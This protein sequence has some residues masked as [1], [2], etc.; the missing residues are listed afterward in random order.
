MADSPPASP[1]PPRSA[2][3][4]PAAAL[5]ALAA[6]RERFLASTENT[7]TAFRGFARQLALSPAAP[8]VVEGLRREL[9]RV[10]GTAGTYGF[11]EASRLAARMEEQA[12]RWAAAPD[13]DVERRA[14]IVEHF[15]EALAAAFVPEAAPPTPPPDAG[16]AGVGAGP[17]ATAPRAPAAPPPPAGAPS[18]HAAGRRRR[19]V[20][21]GID[22]ELSHAVRAEAVL[23]AFTCVTLDPAGCTADALRTLAPH[24]LVADGPHAAAAAAACAVAGVPVIVL[25]APAGVVATSDAALL[26]AGAGAAE[27]LAAAERLAARASWAGATVLV[28]DDDPAVL[29]VVRAVVE[30]SGVHVRTLDDPSAIRAVLVGAPPSLLLMDVDM[31]GENGVAITRELRAIPAYATLPIMLFSARSDPAVRQAAYDA[32]ADEFLPKPIVVDELRARVSDRLER[33]RLQRLSDGLHPGTGLPLP[34]RAAREAGARVSAARLAG[35][36]YTLAVIRPDGAEPAGPAAAAWL[37]ECERVAAHL[38]AGGATVGYHDGAAL[39][40]VMETGAVA[41]VATLRAAL[42]ARDGAAPAWRAG[43]VSGI[44]AP[45]ADLAALRRWAVEAVAAADATGD[46]AVAQWRGELSAEAPDV[47]VVEP[48]PSLSKL[49][50]YALRANGFSFRTFESGPAALA[51]LLSMPVSGRR[52]VVLLDVDLP[53]LD[54][55]SLHE[56]LRGERPG[57]FTVVFT[58]VHGGEAEQV[59]A[60]KGGAVDYIVKPLSVRVLMVKVGIWLELIGRAA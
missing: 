37:R 28:V 60:L 4:P 15:V 6:L 31:G 27:L 2:G 13:L 29:A 49:V 45:A 33:Q 55:H 12:V 3:P 9:H 54:G 8:A 17:P 41:A 52:P 39:L 38:T 46:G 25:G 10:H 24:V 34:P 53:G 56:R 22:G 42:A 26:P 18:L 32:G 21:V 48:D 5:A 20:L 30:G 35:Q 14:V 40:V 58:T 19:F 11:T 51:A 7:L 23:H 36:S 47:I 43:A 50:Q 16:A 44:D 1:P 57:V 59:R